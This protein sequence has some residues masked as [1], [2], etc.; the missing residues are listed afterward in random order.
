MQITDKQLDRFI[1]IYQKHFG[2]ALDRESAYKKGVKLV[3]VMQLILKDNYTQNVK[4]T[5]THLQPKGV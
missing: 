3:E 2:T 1:E 5:C 4:H